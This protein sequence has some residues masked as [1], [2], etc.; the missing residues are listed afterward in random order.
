MIRLKAITRCLLATTALIGAPAAVN[1]QELTAPDRVGLPDAPN[2]MTFRVEPHQ[3]YANTY[4]THAEGF[5]RLFQTFAE[6]HPDWQVRL[7]FYTTDIGGEHA[8]LLEQARAGRAPDCATVDSF[9]LALFIEQG[10]LQPITQFFSE[11]EIEDLF[12]FVREGITGP[13]GQIYAWWCGIP[14][15]ASC[16]ETGNLSPARRRPGMNSRRRPS[17]RRNRK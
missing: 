17:R 2:V 15:F 4:P 11:E 10:M 5:R 9:Q 13:D 6:K 12:P 8:R 16:T 3:T 7:E 14:I 1:A